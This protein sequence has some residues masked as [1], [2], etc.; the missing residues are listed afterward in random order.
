MSVYTFDKADP[1]FTLIAQRI[2]TEMGLIVVASKTDRVLNGWMEYNSATG[3]LKIGFYDADEPPNSSHPDT[4]FVMTTLTSEQE[5]QLADIVGGVNP[6]VKTD[7]PAAIPYTVYCSI[8]DEYYAVY[9]GDWPTA[10]PNCSSTNIT[11]KWH[12]PPMNCHVRSADDPSKCWTCF[13]DKD[14]AIIHAVEV[15]PN[16]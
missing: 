16:A 7:D 5:Q 1:D 12:S 6:V 10:C 4:T 15:F 3:V 11:Q 8:C 9:G 2:K 13:I 14:G